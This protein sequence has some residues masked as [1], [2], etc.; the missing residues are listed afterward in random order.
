MIKKN[1]ICFASIHREEFQNV[2]Q[3]IKNL[4]LNSSRTSNYYTETYT[5]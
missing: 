4:D 2:I 5:F 3:I 1:I